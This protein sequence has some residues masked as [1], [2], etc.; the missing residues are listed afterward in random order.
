[1]GDPQFAL[2][3]K[4]DGDSDQLA[5]NKIWSISCNT[6]IYILNRKTRREADV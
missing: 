3:R 6:V 1:M 4:P 5:G 2:R